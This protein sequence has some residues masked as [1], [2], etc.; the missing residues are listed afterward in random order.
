MA[1]VEI[2]V[3][4]NGEA[5][6]IQA[7]TTFGESHLSEHP[8]GGSKTDSS[9][10][11]GPPPYSKA[12]T[13]EELTIEKSECWREG[14][15]LFTDRL[16]NG[17][18]PDKTLTAELNRFFDRTRTLQK[19]IDRCEEIQAN[20][21][22][23]SDSVG[24]LVDVLNSFKS[25]GDVVLSNAPDAIGAV[26]FAIG[27]VIKIVADDAETCK[28]VAEVYNH[29]SKIAIASLL[30]EERCSRLGS[31]GT[32]GDGNL[33]ALEKVI[34]DNIATLVCEILDFFWNTQR[35]AVKLKSNSAESERNDGPAEPKLTRTLTIREESGVKTKS[36]GF[37]H[38]I[39]HGM[40]AAGK[41]AGEAIKDAVKSGKDKLMEALTGELKEKAQNVLVLYQALHA[42]GTIQFEQTVLDSMQNMGEDV[43]N[44]LQDFK[45]GLDICLHS[46]AGSINR[47]EEKQNMALE[48]AQEL[49][50]KAGNII[51]GQKDLKEGQRE[52]KE[53]Q[54]EMKEMVKQLQDTKKSQ[55]F[56]S[57]INCFRRSVAHE[58]LIQTLYTKKAQDGAANDR[59]WFLKQDKYKDWKSCS[60]ESSRILC[61]E[62]KRG[63]GKT[64]TLLSV[65]SDLET[66]GAEDE[67]GNSESTFVLRFFF[68]LGDN[69]LQST[70]R[71]LESL[72]RQLLKKFSD[73]GGSQT[74][75]DEKVRRICEVLERNNIEKIRDETRKEDITIKDNM[76]ASEETKTPSLISKIISQISAELNLRLYIVLDALDECH[77]LKSSNLVRCL[78]DLAY[79]EASNIWVVVSTRASSQG[80][81]DIENEFQQNDIALNPSPIQQNSPS[82]DIVTLTN[83]ENTEELQLYLELKLRDLVIRRVG[84]LKAVPS[85]AKSKLEGQANL[86][87]DKE[88]VDEGQV[89]EKVKA[90]AKQINKIV[91]GDF[92]YA[93]ML[94]ANLQEPS[95]KSL[96]ARIKELEGRGLE[97]MYR[98]NLDVLTPGKRT[99]ILFALKWVVWSVSDVTAIE[100][101]EHFREV[102]HDTE[103]LEETP[104]S[105]LEESSL[106]TQADY[107]PSDDPEIREVISHLRTAGHDFFSFSSDNDPVTAHTSVREWIQ[108]GASPPVDLRNSEA[109]I[110]KSVGGRLIFEIAVLSDSIPKDYNELSELMSE[111]ESHLSIASDILRALT[112]KSFQERY[113]P[114]NPPKKYVEKLWKKK[115][116]QRQESENS[117]EDE[118]RPKSSQSDQENKESK[119]RRYEIRHWV[120]HIKALEGYRHRT[121]EE[122]KNP[123]WDVLKSLLEKFIKPEN[124]Y[125]W[126]IQRRIMGGHDEDWAYSTNCYQEPI[127]VASLLG[128]QFLIDHLYSSS[129]KEGDAKSP[130]A[131]ADP[132]SSDAESVVEECGVLDRYDGAGRIPL[133][134]AL[135]D[136]KTVEYLLK[137]GAQVN[138]RLLDS[139]DTSLRVAL[140]LADTEKEDRKKLLE[141]VKLLLKYGAKDQISVALERTIPLT[142]DEDSTKE[143]IAEFQKAYSEITVILLEKYDKEEEP[144]DAG[145]VFLSAMKAAARC[146]TQAQEIWKRAESLLDTD[147]AGKNVVERQN[148]NALTPLHVLTR[149]VYDH[150]DHAE[151]FIPMIKQLFKKGADP[152]VSYTGFKWKPY[153]GNPVLL[154]VQARNS[155]LFDI[156]ARKGE[157]LFQS[158]SLSGA[159]AMHYFFKEKHKAISEDDKKL[160]ERLLKLSPQSETSNEA[161][162]NSKTETTEDK[163]KEED[164]AKVPY[165]IN[166]E[167]NDSREPLSWAIEYGDKDG[168]ALLIEHKAD[169]DDV[170]EI[171]RTALYYLATEQNDP[172]DSIAMLRDLHKAGA[173]MRISPVNRKTVFC[174]AVCR[175]PPSVL[176]EFVRILPHIDR[177]SELDSEDPMHE[178]T[179]IDGE[180]L[181]QADDRGKNFLHCHYDRDEEDDADISDILEEVI[182]SLTEDDR[183]K[184]LSQRD[185]DKSATPLRLAV[186]E[187]NLPL[188]NVLLKYSS[189]EI[190]APTEGSPGKSPLKTIAKNIAELEDKISKAKGRTEIEDRKGSLG[191]GSTDTQ[192]ED[193]PS[194][195]SGKASSPIDYEKTMMGLLSVSTINTEDSWLMRLREFAIKMSWSSFLQA[196]E[197]RGVDL[198]APDEYGWNAFHL[199]KHHGTDSSLFENRSEELEVL[200]PKP[201][202]LKTDFPR[203]EFRGQF[204]S[205]AEISE[206]GLEVTTGND[207]WMVQA[208]RPIDL[209]SGRYY[210]E[211]QVKNIEPSSFEDIGWSIGI[212]PVHAEIDSYYQQVG[213]NVGLGWHGDDGS[214]RDNTDPS[215][216]SKPLAKLPE[217]GRDG[218]G[219]MDTVGLGIDRE[220]GSIFFTKNGELV[221]IVGIKIKTRY[222]PAFSMP[223]ECTA[224]VNFEKETFQYRGWE[225]CIEDIEASAKGSGHMAEWEGDGETDDSDDSDDSDDT[226]D[227]DASSDS[228][229]DDYID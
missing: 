37:G 112:N 150:P 134:L 204:P 183:K 152:L 92:S 74:Q 107:D 24:T 10:S 28:I 111:E 139:E 169:V 122:A 86:G 32:G 161:S 78:K 3:E 62:A 106:S 140:R 219:N 194:K 164:T 113:M 30:Y 29:V 94:I 115:F 177:R 221:G 5:T 199:A 124:W 109:R 207:G 185:N 61:L 71:A 218:D 33:I 151:T 36:R 178:S 138:K 9:P 121:A 212:I 83:K 186:K 69:E 146:P 160:F 211:V 54:K 225:G 154:A 118:N 201:S 88:V 38:A 130:D 35:W 181:L 153:Y 191:S 179:Q 44:N 47:I 103:V 14:R 131:E 189:T 73:E 12:L 129:E 209:L 155:K 70:L 45:K 223:D 2:T 46:L 170:D 58:N 77:D 110:V 171:G 1:A 142:I 15:R 133:S 190:E 197:A 23:R 6:Q 135:R 104:S 13:K 52:M 99:L 168:V 228:Y 119:R 85:A 75:L 11:S 192:E 42:D 202:K 95:K 205:F 49:D 173:D 132:D 180:Y 226:G 162:G 145:A 144:L 172:V 196:L 128:L 102:Y 117:T 147:L 43:R 16:T 184:L 81:V 156:F 163:A 166:A 193:E 63:H 89:V 72:L 116:P 200:M 157:S 188:I 27:F 120:E 51:E 60:S 143:N 20:A 59:S 98:R 19:T 56:E 141:S 79:A 64:M 175:Q 220:S 100:I 97:D 25:V 165:F 82:A 105:P 203:A 21:E 53:E 182:Q 80:N 40:K 215:V 48:A 34:V 66:Y 76:A 65:T 222:I 7:S 195:V 57:Y 229:D 67:G 213:L 217:W 8:G 114:W 167:D 87:T 68:K 125:R 4:T 187:L 17:K 210:F 126:H 50:N 149:A 176:R 84:K 148:K 216:D 227:S 41:K 108:N 93:G 96:E 22:K 31:K 18:A 26:W 174:Q 39:G 136:P 90:L 123:K 91:N 127:H 158:K 214:V 137:V 101:A 206:D 159:C 208:N 198:E 224:R 55:A